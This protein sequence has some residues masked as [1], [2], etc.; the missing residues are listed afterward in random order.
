MQNNEKDEIASFLEGSTDF[1]KQPATEVLEEWQKKIA[2]LSMGMNAALVQFIL[3]G[4]IPPEEQMHFI[5]HLHDFIGRIYSG[6]AIQLPYTRQTLDIN[7]KAGNLFYKAS[8]DSISNGHENYLRIKEAIGA[9]K[10]QIQT[11][12]TK[13][14]EPSKPTVH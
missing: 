10:A 7:S 1:G 4:I 12:E 8:E 6:E 11:E 14:D 5:M 2:A 3:E 9:A 13:S